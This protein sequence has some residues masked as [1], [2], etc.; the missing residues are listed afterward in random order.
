M[1]DHSITTK[2]HIRELRVSN[3]A[4]EQGG[5]CLTEA[6]EFVVQNGRKKYS[7]FV[8]YENK[9]VILQRYILS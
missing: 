6:C 1:C 3:S 7:N 2:T 5:C 9:D 4:G 8:T